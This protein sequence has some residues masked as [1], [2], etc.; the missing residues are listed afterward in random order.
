M[1]TSGSNLLHVH[2]PGTFFLA[3]TDWII[4]SYNTNSFI[5]VDIM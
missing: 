3:V 1:C 5:T 2:V 4:F